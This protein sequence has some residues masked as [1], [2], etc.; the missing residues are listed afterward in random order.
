[1]RGNSTDITK[2]PNQNLNTTRLVSPFKDEQLVNGKTSAPFNLENERKNIFEGIPEHDGPFLPA[3][4]GSTNKGSGGLLKHKSE[5]KRMDK[6]RKRDA[7]QRV[8]Q[9]DQLT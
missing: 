5:K 6:Q 2:S 8:K 3:E 1:L 9:I 4:Y 7:R